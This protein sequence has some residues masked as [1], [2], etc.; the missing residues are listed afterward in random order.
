[1][2][3]EFIY[4]LAGSLELNVQ[5][6]VDIESEDCAVELLEVMCNGLEID[7][8]DIY[9]GYGKKQD[10]LEDIL[11]GEAD[12]QVSIELGPRYE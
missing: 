11:K 9:I 12:H 3:V 4:M 5:A 8:D 7:I 1:M 10:A 6:Y 2:I